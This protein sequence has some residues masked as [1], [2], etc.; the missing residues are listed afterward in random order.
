LV[1]EDADVEREKA[2]VLAMGLE[3]RLCDMEEDMKRLNTDLSAAQ[4]RVFGTPEYD[5]NEDGNDDG[6]NRN[7]GGEEKEGTESGTG[8]TIGYHPN[9]HNNNNNNNI[10]PVSSI[11]NKMNRHHDILGNLEGKVKGIEVELATLSR[12]MNL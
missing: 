5:D 3:S 2:Y 7:N 9:N 10:N 1:P 6:I 12:E 8:R 11:V 4:E